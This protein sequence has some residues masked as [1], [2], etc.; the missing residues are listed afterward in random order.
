MK[1]KSPYYNKDYGIPCP[2]GQ[3]MPC[4]INRRRAWVT[5]LIL[6]NMMH[7]KAVFITLTYSDEHLP[8]K[9][10]LSSRDL[11]LFFK[12]LRKRIAPAKIRYFA[13]GEYGERFKRPHYHAII[14]GLENCHITWQFVHECW[15]KGIIDVGSVTKDSISY[16]AGYV[17]KKIGSEDRERIK[18]GEISREFCRMSLKPAIG[19]SALDE[20]AKYALVQGGF[21]VIQTLKIG[22]K[23]LPVPKYIRR[24]LRSRFFSD[25][26]IEKLKEAGIQNARDE[27]KALIRK[28][29]GLEASMDYF[30][31]FGSERALANCLEAHN[32][33]HISSIRALEDIY[34]QKNKRRSLE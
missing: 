6:E 32:L 22:D 1:C 30:T 23:V 14:F 18:S 33:E 3:C 13:C 21:D 8:E 31:D 26:Y 27:L 2:C 4:R 24:K 5:R 19:A 11:Q 28:H 12:R 15:N 9:G 34:N 17:S 29:L 25:E 10:S 7:D 16:V 20:F